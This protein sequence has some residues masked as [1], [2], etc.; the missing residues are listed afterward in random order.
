MKRSHGKQAGKS[1]NLT[2]KPRLSPTKELA[3]YPIGTMVRID[4]NP[5]YAEGQPH[6]RFNHKMAKI[7]GTQ[8]NA[9][10]IAVK[11]GNKLK[12]LNISFIHLS[13]I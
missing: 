12:T 3:R 10:V 11:D 13:R 6:L 2:K 8:G 9:A 4:V 1:R 5:A 7:S